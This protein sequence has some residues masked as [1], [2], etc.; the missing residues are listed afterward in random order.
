MHA[1]KNQYSNKL[2]NNKKYTIRKSKSCNLCKFNDSCMG[3]DE[4]YVKLYGL[5]EISPIL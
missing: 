5:D 2:A 3:L 1:E 4:R